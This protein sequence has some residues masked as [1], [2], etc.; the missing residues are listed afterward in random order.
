MAFA[1]LTGRESLRDIEASLAAAGSKTYRMGFRSA[2]RRNTLA[3]ANQKRDCRIF[4]DF[5]HAL[6]RMARP[7]YADEPLGVQLDETIYA[8]DATTIDLCL[9]LFPWAE[10]RSTKSAMKL[11]TLLDVRGSIPCEIRVTPG[12]AHETSVL[13][14]FALEPG[15]F[16]IVDR[17]YIDYTWFR[18]VDQTG[19]WFVTRAKKNLNARRLYSHHVDKTAGVRSDQTVALNGYYA[20]RN[21]PDHLRRVSYWDKDTDTRLI[22]LTNNFKLPALKIA[23]LYK[24]RWRVELFFKWIKQH[25]RIKSFFGTSNNAVKTQVWIAISVY[26]TVAIMKKRLKLP[27]SLY[28]ILQILSVVVFEKMTLLQAFRCIDYKID[29]EHDAIQLNLFD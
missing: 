3:N 29:K 25:L 18:E 24:L 26:V 28:T 17:G 1:Q 5:T 4:E 20:S 8:L 12:R 19:A 14:S 11:H 15:A 21:Y 9:S 13:D 2:V 16:Y 6:I 23:Q 10:F 27:H 7:M 22:F